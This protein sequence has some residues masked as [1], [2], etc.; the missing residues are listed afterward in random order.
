MS[1]CA[2]PLAWALVPSEVPAIMAA[3]PVR[4][5]A[6]LPPKF[7]APPD[8]VIAPR[9][10]LPI[11]AGTVIELKIQGSWD[12]A[13]IETS[14]TTDLP[15]PAVLDQPLVVGGKKVLDA[16]SA[17]I[18]KGRIIGAGSRFEPVQTRPDTVQIAFTT[19]EDQIT[20]RCRPWEN[21][22]I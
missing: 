12:G 22:R 17:V 3:P 6:E 20:R 13:A 1:A 11:P 16:H 18:L 5:M 8:V 14:T 7:V 10:P 21:G 19:D 9:P 4:T 2:R 15:I